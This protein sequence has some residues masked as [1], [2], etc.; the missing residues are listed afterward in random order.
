MYITYYRILLCV[1]ACSII[2]L[3]NNKKFILQGNGR[4]CPSPILMRF[5]YVVKYQKILDPYFFIVVYL[6]GVKH[7]LENNRSF[8]FQRISSKL[9]RI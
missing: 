7:P 3:D 5:E 8:R 1:S 4:N 6:K 9:C 2:I